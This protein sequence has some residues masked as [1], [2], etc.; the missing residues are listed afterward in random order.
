MGRDGTVPPG[1]VRNSDGCASRPT[2]R[3]AQLIELPLE[4]LPCR[5]IPPRPSFAPSCSRP[6]ARRSGGRSARMTGSPGWLAESAT[7]DVR[8]GGEGRRPLRR[9]ARAPGAR[10]RGRAR[11]LDRV[12]LGAGLRC[13]DAE[14]RVE[15]RLEDAGDGTTRIT[16]GRDGLRERRRPRR[17]A[18]RGRSCLGLGGSAGG[19]SP[20][21]S[22]SSPL[23]SRGGRRR[24]V[25]GAR[26]PDAPRDPTG[27]PAGRR[28]RRA[29]SRAAADQPSG[30]LEAPRALADG[31]SR[32]RPS[33]TVARR[34][35]GRRPS[36]WPRLRRG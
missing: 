5:T 3:Y 26:R 24:R 8:P 34:A 27:S 21:C 12:P 10:R 14:T 4:E 16:V 30:G 11:E 20:P 25:R 18:P 19:C 29:S 7:V 6:I 35:T 33:A 15:L 32:R 28:T 1:M 17:R 31:G 23:R 9:R 36:R 2:S 22:C 13:R